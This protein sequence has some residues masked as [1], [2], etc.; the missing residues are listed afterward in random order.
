MRKMLALIL[1]TL[2]A[3]PTAS[4]QSTGEIQKKVLAIPLGS[5]VEVRLA[6]KTKVLGRLG[7]AFETGFELQYSKADKVETRLIPFGEVK[8]I[9][10]TTKQS[11]GSKVGKTVLKTVIILGIIATVGL[12]VYNNKLK[13]RI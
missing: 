10:D 4:A 12:V 8:S 11:A 6:N 13:D 5:P 3:T 9:R 2:I 1:V 7:T